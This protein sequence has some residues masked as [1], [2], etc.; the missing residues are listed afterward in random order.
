MTRS[1]GR[2]VGTLLPAIA[3]GLVAMQAG[4]NTL[5]QNVSW[6]I[7]RSGTSTK[8]RVGAYGYSIFAGYNGA[9]LQPAKHAA[10]PVHAE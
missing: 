5:N 10:P 1:I 4:A 9:S 7:D 6:T 2:T 8:Y 3:L